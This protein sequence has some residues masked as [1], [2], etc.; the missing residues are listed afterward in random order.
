MRRR[1]L[2]ATGHEPTYRIKSGDGLKAHNFISRH[3]RY[4]L[5]AVRAV[6]KYHFQPSNGVTSIASMSIIQAFAFLF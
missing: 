6:S 3:S 2:L 5:I 1:S 4:Y